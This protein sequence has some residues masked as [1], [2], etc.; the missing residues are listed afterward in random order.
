MAIRMDGQIKSD[1]AFWNRDESDHRFLPIPGTNFTVPGLTS[2]FLFGK[3][4]LVGGTDVLTVGAMSS[5]MIMGKPVLACIGG[6]FGVGAISSQSG[7]DL[8]VLSGP[9]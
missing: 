1:V 2:T 5:S 8:V 7:M 9:N 3:P 4:T 6:T